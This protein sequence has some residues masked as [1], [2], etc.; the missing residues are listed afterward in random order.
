MVSQNLEKIY[1]EGF[2]LVPNSRWQELFP[3]SKGTFIAVYPTFQRGVYKSKTIQGTQSNINFC[4]AGKIYAFAELNKFIEF[5]D[6]KDWMLFNKRA[7][8]HIYGPANSISSKNVV[9]HGN[10]RSKSLVHELAK[11]D[12]ALLPYPSGAEDQ[13][14]A[15]LSFP[16]K[17]LSYLAASLPVI[18]IGNTEA[19][20]CN[21][22][23]RTGISI[24]PNEFSKNFESEFARLLSS[25][26]AVKL[27]IESLL[28]KNFSEEN[29]L[30]AISDWLESAG[31]TGDQMLKKFSSARFEL[32]KGNFTDF[33]VKSKSSMIS[34]NVYN[35]RWYIRTPKMRFVEVFFMRVLYSSPVMKLINVVTVFSIKIYNS[36]VL[37]SVFP[38]SR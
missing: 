4:F 29:L 23:K 31:I 12:Y 22:T 15:R 38:S 33:L 7:I 20:V 19:T 11:H 32:T 28:S 5:M 3:N 6:S 37:R 27:N 26:E 36:R 30:N 25:R 8:L 18:Y 16:S 17:Y 9:Y 2:H 14:I 13:D 10:L 21:F 1:S 35:L 34:E 24:N